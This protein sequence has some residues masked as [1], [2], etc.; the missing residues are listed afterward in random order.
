MHGVDLELA[1]DEPQSLTDGDGI[2]MGLN[3]ELIAVGRFD[4]SQSAVHPAV[5]LGAE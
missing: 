5:V 1:H 4:A 2:R 3:N